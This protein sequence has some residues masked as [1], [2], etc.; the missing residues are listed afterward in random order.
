VGIA[1]DPVETDDREQHLVPHTRPFLGGE[2]VPRGGAEV[3]HGLGHVD[4]GPVA[5]V[6]DGIDLVQCRVEPLAGGQVHAERP[7]DPYDLM[8]VPLEGR[9]GACSDV[10]GGTGDRDPH[11]VTVSRTKQIFN[12]DDM[13]GP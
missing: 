7:A 9:D 1:L 4:R 2:Q 5:G 13:V 10:A 12:I 11:A 3:R 8:P 6:D